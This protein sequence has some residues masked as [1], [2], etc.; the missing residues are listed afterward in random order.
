MNPNPFTLPNRP[1][2]TI[3]EVLCWIAGKRGAVDSA[4]VAARFK[5][6]RNDACMRLLRL[7][8]YGYLRRAKAAGVYAYELTDFG[9]KSAR[10]WGE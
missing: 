9:A 10:K 2:L 5:V 8:R 4:A 1:H 3:R 7:H 6:E